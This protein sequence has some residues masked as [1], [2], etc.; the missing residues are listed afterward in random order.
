MRDRI[1]HD[2]HVDDD[3]RNPITQIGCGIETRS[4]YADHKVLTLATRQLFDL[5][6]QSNNHHI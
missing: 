3:D 1:Q 5:M 6:V 2:D 4:T